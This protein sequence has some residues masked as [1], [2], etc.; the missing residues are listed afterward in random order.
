[1]PRPPLSV[2]TGFFLR[3]LAWLVPLLALWYAAR[4]WM[5]LPPAWL[6][7]QVMRGFFH[8][9][10]TGSEIDGTTQTLLTALT[11]RAPDGRIGELLPTANILTYAYGTPLAAALLLASR[12]QGWWWKIPLAALALVPFQAASVCCTWLMQIAV[13]AGTDTASQTGFSAWQ[14]NLFA[15][16]YQLGFLLL[17]TLMPV[18]AWLALDRS[19]VAKVMLEGAFAATRK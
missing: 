18:L 15:A 5:A 6:A 14:A 19:L 12:L 11:V 4:E 10:V 1:M 16:G 7:E 8:Y 3:T 2:V 13:L 9:W 17:P